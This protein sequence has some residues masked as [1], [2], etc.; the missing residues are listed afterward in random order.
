VALGLENP[1]ADWDT[2]KDSHIDK[3][4]HKLDYVTGQSGH[5]EALS[6]QL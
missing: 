3:N 5:Q 6:H 2:G 4:V 1:K